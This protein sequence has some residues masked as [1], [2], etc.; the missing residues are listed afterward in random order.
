VNG[1][2]RS[3]PGR[4]RYDAETKTATDSATESAPGKNPPKKPHPEK[5]P[6]R[7]NALKMPKMAI[8]GLD[9]KI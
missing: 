7:K 3:H 2:P 5:K 9:K 8:G 6:S 4:I 1:T